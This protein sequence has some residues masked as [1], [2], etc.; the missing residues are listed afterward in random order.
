MFNN[1]QSFSTLFN[2]FLFCLPLEDE[3]TT[4]RAAQAPLTAMPLAAQ[5][6]RRMEDT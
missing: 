6:D 4:L 5:P 1:F 3:F 2:S